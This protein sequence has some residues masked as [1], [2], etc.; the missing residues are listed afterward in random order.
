LPRVHFA[1]LAMSAL[2]I[3][4]S[5]RCRTMVQAYSVAVQ[6]AQT[7]WWCHYWHHCCSLCWCGCASW[8]RRLLLVQE[9]GPACELQHH[10]VFLILHTDGMPHAESLSAAEGN[11]A[12]TAGPPLRIERQHA[13][14]T[15]PRQ[16]PNSG[17]SFTVCRLSRQRTCPHAYQTR[18]QQIP[19]IQPLHYSFLGY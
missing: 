10:H 6:C 7:Q 3:R 8:C 18:H 16:V 4:G 2:R 19:N 13:F 5:A 1:L 14:V 15:S 17:L 12:P 11:S 9:E